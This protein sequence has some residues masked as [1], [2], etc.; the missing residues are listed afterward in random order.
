MHRPAL[1]L[2]VVCTAAC[3]ANPPHQAIEQAYFKCDASKSLEGGIYNKGP[4]MRFGP[5]PASCS[6]P[7]WTRVTQPE[8]K[9]LATQWY[10]KDW[11]QE[12]PFWR[13]TGE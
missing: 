11:S 9:A 3:A 1:M 6:S 7:E 2:L 10:G 4:F 5:H 8:F 13:R 12:I